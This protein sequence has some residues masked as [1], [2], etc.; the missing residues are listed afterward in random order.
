MISGEQQETDGALD[1][2]EYTLDAA[3]LGVA[4]G[5]IMLGHAISEEARHAR[6]G[7]VD[8]GIRPRSAGSA[9]EGG[10]AVLVSSLVVPSLLLYGGHMIRTAVVSS[11][12]IAG[13]LTLPATAVRAAPDAPQSAG[14]ITAADAAP[15]VGDWT[16]TL[17]G[18]N[19]P[20]TFDLSIKVEQDKVVGEIK[21]AEL[22][23]QAITDIT[24]VDKSLFLRY[25][26]DYQGNQVPTVVSLDA[27]RGRQDQGAD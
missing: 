25:S 15:F 4:K 17:E 13:L 6:D 26:F 12:L 5:W 3:T 10:R 9:R 27:R 7:A 2:P 23:A 24:K 20:A 22:P 11:V 16:L 8:Q 18:P 21:S 19:G 1:S 14:Q